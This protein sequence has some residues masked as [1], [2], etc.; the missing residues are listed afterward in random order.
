MVAGCLLDLEDR[1]DSPDMVAYCFLTIRGRRESPD[2]VAGCLLAGKLGQASAVAADGHLAQGSLHLASSHGLGLH[3]HMSKVNIFSRSA[4]YP[5][6]H[7][8]TWIHIIFAGYYLQH[9]PPWIWIRIQLKR[10]GT[11]GG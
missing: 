10:E 11:K 4:A 2:M 7:G 8:P 6:L 9:W 1:R 3:P 5:D